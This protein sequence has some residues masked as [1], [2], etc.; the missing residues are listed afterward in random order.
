[1][2]GVGDTEAAKLTVSLDKYDEVK[3]TLLK[4]GVELGNN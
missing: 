2:E 4:A 3:S 1:V